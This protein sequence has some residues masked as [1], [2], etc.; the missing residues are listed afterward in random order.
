MAVNNKT[1]RDYYEEI[2]SK[3]LNTTYE[4]LIAYHQRTIKDP[5][6]M[7]KKIVDYFVMMLEN[8]RPITFSGAQ[9]SLGCVSKEAFYKYRH[10]VRAHQ[11]DFTECSLLISKCI[12]QFNEEKLYGKYYQGARFILSCNNGY[13]AT[14]KVITENHTVEVTIGKPQNNEQ[15]QQLE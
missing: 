10:E 2:F 5:Q 11:P 13:I 8:D 7:A 14:E 1:Y 9:L 12:E 15:T 4:E 3:Y 6:M